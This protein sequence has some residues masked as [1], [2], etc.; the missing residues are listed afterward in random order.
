MN[1]FV[2][3]TLIVPVTR[4]EKL[5]LSPSPFEQPYKKYVL[6]CQ[7]HGIVPYL[8]GSLRHLY[9]KFPEVEIEIVRENAE[10]DTAF[11]Q[12]L[13]KTVGAVTVW[14]SMEEYKKQE[15]G[16]DPVLYY[17]FA[18][19]RDPKYLE[20]EERDKKTKHMIECLDFF[21]EK[22]GNQFVL[23]DCIPTL[24]KLPDTC[25]AVAEREYEVVYAAKPQNSLEKYVLYLEDILRE[26]LQKGRQ[27]KAVR[28]T[29]VFGPG[30]WEDD[31]LFVYSYI[32][33]AV[34]HHKVVLRPDKINSYYSAAYIPDAVTALILIGHLGREGNI[35]HVS[36][37]TLTEYQAANLIYSNVE[38]E[39][40]LSIEEGKKKPASYHVL[41]AKKSL[42]LY[43]SKKLNGSLITSMEKA[44]KMTLLSY[45]GVEGYVETNPFNVYYGRISRIREIE[46]DIL[47]DVDKICKEHNIK[48]F[49][50][51]GSMLGA[52]RHKGFI[53]WDDDL[54]IA[55]LPEDYEKF[56]K[57]CP[58]H[59]ST[60]FGYQNWSTEKTSHYIHDKIR[61]KNTYFSTKY[62]NQ[63]QM[64][65]GV[66]M[67]V[68]VYYKT[69]N[70]P[71]MQN[72]HLYLI[73]AWRRIIGL[74]WAGYARK[75]IHYYKSKMVLPIMKRIPF[76]WFH[77]RYMGLLK[78]YEKRKNCKYRIDAMGFNL[79]KVGAFPDEWFH[80]LTEGEFEG[81]KYPIPVH[82][83]DY[84]R[85]WYGD[86]YMELLPVS[87]RTSVHDVIRIDLGE[88]LTK[89]S[90]GKGFHQ[91]DLRGE[92]FE[93]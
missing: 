68:F 5:N 51:G 28:L 12:E 58:D 54:D 31:D 75:N 55:M 34:D 63:Y 50:A 6:I 65:N 49:L 46:L 13:Q 30:F 56:L 92:L 8:A 36:S 45:Q 76:D 27:V 62:S 26:Y 79:R 70:S 83:D 35:Y 84:L 42:L 41:N 82:Y 1:E 52:I 53:P 18:N 23:A 64:Y 29:N 10:A 88:Y 15:K 33:D 87:Q 81:K 24:E 61:I 59:L 20:K 21:A 9:R 32:K 74:R 40:Q 48:Y 44:L 3:D 91:A 37:N 19:L 16:T 38:Q 39:A 89:D 14:D 43:Y 57:V 4:I 77:K 73:N 47:N 7:E 78:L 67:D 69:S 86:H 2:Y 72:L 93:A 80:D 11:C 25:N 60:E 90:V 22:E 66:Y 17:Y 71:R 85:H